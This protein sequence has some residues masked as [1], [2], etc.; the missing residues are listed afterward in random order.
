MIMSVP[1][2]FLKVKDLNALRE[3]MP[4]GT[5]VELV[6]NSLM[7]RAVGGVVEQRL[8][9]KKLEVNQSERMAKAW[10]PII[11]SS[12][13]PAAPTKKKASSK[14]VSASAK[15]GEKAEKERLDKEEKVLARATFYKTQ[16]TDE[17]CSLDVKTLMARIAATGGGAAAENGGG[18]KNKKNAPP[19]AAPP[20][21]VLPDDDTPKFVSPRPFDIKQW[22]LASPMLKGSNLWFFVSTELQLRDTIKAY[23]S[24]IEKHPEIVD[25]GRKACKE[26]DGDGLERVMRGVVMGD[27]FDE[28]KIHET[29]SPKEISDDVKGGGI[30]P[31]PPGDPPRIKGAILEG[32]ILS[33]ASV[34][35]V[36][37]LP[38]RGEVIGKIAGGI[39]SVAAGLASSLAAPLQEVAAAF[40]A[41]V[42]KKGEEGGGGEKKAE[43][44]GGGE[45]KAEGGDA[46]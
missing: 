41:V 37:S 17:E 2:N 46:K 1:S 13:D 24:Y 7:G 33:S 14:T 15:E 38:P 40:A 19:P 10:R 26:D 12:D 35:I 39:S 9:E 27:E 28:W 43:E 3:V 45:K 31:Q 44:G 5:K 18:D 8:L 20:V 16:E 23:V 21:V 6:K 42:E 30:R 32:S 36:G 29:R 11:E 22:S 25:K 34:E 4:S